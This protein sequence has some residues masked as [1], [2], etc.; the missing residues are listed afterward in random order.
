VE[1]AEP[2]A[3]GYAMSWGRKRRVAS[4][5]T[6][7]SHTLGGTISAFLSRLSRFQA[8]LRAIG[9][10][11]LIC[12][13]GDRRIDEVPGRNRVQRFAR[14]ASGASLLDPESSLIG[15]RNSLFGC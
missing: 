7:A 5:H 13:F 2:E 9:V 6:T 12:L 3:E 8:P 10:E 4:P 1:L 15:P 11:L 14:C